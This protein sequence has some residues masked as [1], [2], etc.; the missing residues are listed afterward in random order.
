[1]LNATVILPEPAAPGLLEVLGLLELLHAASRPADATAS[2]A[3]PRRA[4]DGLAGRE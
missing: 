4:A 2:K 3:M 1:M